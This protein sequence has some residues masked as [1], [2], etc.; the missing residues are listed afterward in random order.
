MSAQAFVSAQNPPKMILYGNSHSLAPMVA[1]QFCKVPFERLHSIAIFLYKM[2]LL[3]KCLVEA[4]DKVEV[5][6]L[7]LSHLFSAGS[8]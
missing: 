3:I 8:P 6:I 2:H 5:Q 4:L 7:V 1:A